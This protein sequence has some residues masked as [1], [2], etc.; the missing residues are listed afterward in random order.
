M[1]QLE[2]LLSLVFINEPINCKNLLSLEGIIRNFLWDDTE[3][4]H[5]YHLVLWDIICLSKACG[6]LGVRNIALFNIVLKENG[7]GDLGWRKSLEESG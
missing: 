6:G 1:S 7:C 2:F 3:E 4:R 5:T